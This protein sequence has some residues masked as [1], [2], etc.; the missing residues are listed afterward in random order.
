[1]SKSIHTSV[2]VVNVRKGSTIARVNTNAGTYS[3]SLDMAAALQ[4]PEYRDSRVVLDIAIVADVST[5][6]GVTTRDGAFSFSA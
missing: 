3:A 5:I 6:V 4:R 2:N 1:M